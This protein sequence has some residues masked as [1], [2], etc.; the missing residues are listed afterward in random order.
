MNGDALS[1]LLL[2]G[3]GLFFAWRLMTQRPGLAI[4]MGLVG[5]AAG[6][7]V[8]RFS[9]F[10]VMLGPHRFASLLAG[11]AGLPL[12]AASIRWPGESLATRVSAAAYFAMI[13]GALGVVLVAV[14]QFHWWSQLVPAACALL[15]LLT[16]L[17]RRFPLAILGSGLLIGGFIVS[18]T[19]FVV[20]PLNSIQLLHILLASGLGLLALNVQPE[21]NS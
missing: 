3:V 13:V 16:A 11:C 2:A 19:G 10:E 12:I 4:G 21:S 9:G 20:A 8:L 1:D 18:V 17:Q 7:G 15:L 14:A 5:L 6:F